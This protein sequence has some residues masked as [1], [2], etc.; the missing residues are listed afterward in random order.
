VANLQGLLAA[1]LEE[2]PAPLRQAP[3]VQPVLGLMQDT[4]AR[5]QHTLASL[6]ELG[7]LQLDAAP[8]RAPLALAAVVEDVRQDLQPL[9][10]A[11]GARLEVDLAG[12]PSVAFSPKH[13]R[14]VVYNLVSNALK[15]RHPER[16]PV[17]HVRARYTGDRVE[18]AVQDN[19]VGGMGSGALPRVFAQ[20]WGPSPRRSRWQEA[21]GR[22]VPLLSA[23]ASTR[24]R[25]VV[26][27]GVRGKRPRARATLS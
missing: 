16:A 15:Y 19:G 11:T 13:L 24:T 14:S 7:R 6:T 10:A 27:P 12:N 1:L 20:R 2:L 3:P 23:E 4:I 9:L 21:A 25:R 8:P 22:S 18:L 26:R 17:V 5:F